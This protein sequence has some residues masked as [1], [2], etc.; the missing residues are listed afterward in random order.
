[1]AIW[2]LPSILPTTLRVY[3]LQHCEYTTYNI[4]NSSL[5]YI[6]EL[7]FRA[8]A[9]RQNKKASLLAPP[10][11]YAKVLQGSCFLSLFSSSYYKD[12]RADNLL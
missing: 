9:L 8:L 3:Y 11:S 4:A 10:F 6:I 2:A 7:T 12:T 1:M 5:K